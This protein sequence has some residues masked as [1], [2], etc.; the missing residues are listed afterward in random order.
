VSAAK[1]TGLLL[2]VSWLA[3]VSVR[4]RSANLFNA[5]HPAFTYL[6]VVFAGWV[7]LSA[8]WAEFPSAVFA[9]LVRIIPNAT[10]FF[11]VF[12]A[13]RTRQQTNWM[14]G[15][16]VVGALASA[17]YGL[18]TPT[19]P[20]ALDRLSGAAGNANVTA[21]MLVSGAV[22][23][24]ALAATLRDQ[25]LLRLAA[26]VAAP[27]CLFAMFLTLSRGGLVS[28]GASLIAAVAVS[29]RWRPAVTGVALLAVLGTVLYFGAFAPAHARD[30]VT[31]LGS[32]TGREDIWKVGWRMVEAHPV[33]GV[34]AGNFSHVSVHYLLAPGAITNANFIVDT[35][36][37]AHNSYLEVLAELGVIGLVLFLG[38]VGFSLNSLLR[39][40]RRF[41]HDG[42]RN[43]EI[44]SRAV[45]VAIIGILAADFFGSREY[46]K[47]L[48]LLMALG[49][50]LL[51]IASA[52]S[53]QAAAPDAEGRPAP[54]APPLARPR[55]V[56]S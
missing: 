52:R 38:I 12:S 7:T 55:A 44:V 29:G 42:E 13:I 20:H 31:K 37:V 34:G 24:G 46:A 36:K 35:P 54:I 39:A 1:V 16:F 11:I 18:I 47:Q 53:E 56:H 19:D 3:L 28:L 21:S 48:W 49:P 43:M 51:A 23:A 25:P 26:A 33:R 17:I 6:L 41:E 5:V 30:R 50:A 14:L 22:L 10:L 15:A 2:A 4:G 40:I 32:G 9:D 27:F 45:F 8:M